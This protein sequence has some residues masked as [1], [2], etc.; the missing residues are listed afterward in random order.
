LVGSPNQGSSR[1][2]LTLQSLGRLQK[3][4]NKKER[5]E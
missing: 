4:R 1:S 5:R 3:F 2:N